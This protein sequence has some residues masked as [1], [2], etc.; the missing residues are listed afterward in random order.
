MKA[1]RCF[2]QAVAVLAAFTVARSFG[3]LG[4]AAIAVSL[5]T[6]ALAL[7]TSALGSLCPCFMP[8]GR[9]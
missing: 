3:L 9:H 4:P 6:V 2:V 7:I 8:R 1:G 5:L